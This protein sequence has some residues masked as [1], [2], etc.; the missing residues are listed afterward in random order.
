MEHAAEVYFNNI[1]TRVAPF[2]VSRSGNASDIGKQRRYGLLSTTDPSADSQREFAALVKQ[3]LQRGCPN[4]APLDISPKAY[5]YPNNGFYFDSE[6][7]Q[8]SAATTNIA[9][10]QTDGVTTI[11]WLSGYETR[12]SEAAAN[13]E[14]YPEWVVA[15][16]LQNDQ[17]EENQYN[18]GFPGGQHPDSF[19]YAWFVSPQLREDRSSDQ[20]C[21]TAF[22]ESFPDGT[23]EMESESCGMYRGYFMLFRSI[24]VA[25]PVLTPDAM[26]Q[27]NHAVKRQES[28]SPH[29]AACFFDPGDYSCVKDAQESWWDPDAPDPRGG[30][31][32]TGCLRMVNDGVRRLASTWPEGDATAEMQPDNVCNQPG[33][34]SS[35]IQ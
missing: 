8:V 33:D 25:G 3:K 35:N 16:D 19:Q 11:L 28:I 21:R 18:N 15:G 17:L 9:Q 5:T 14:W 7:E 2:S 32:A 34:N 12:H 31:A 24:Q 29:V 13:A 26:D 22:R 20:P 10:M 23:N 6:T 4:G 30:N 27:G 1:C